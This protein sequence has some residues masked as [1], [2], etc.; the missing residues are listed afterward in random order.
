MTPETVAVLYP[1]AR[2]KARD[3]PIAPRL[4]DLNGKVLGLLWNTKPNGDILLRRIQERLA[5]RFKLSNTV[6]RQKPGAAMSA[7]NII[8]EFSETVDAVINALGD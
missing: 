3:V 1:T 2:A 8:K 4:D 5:E 7:G 6:W